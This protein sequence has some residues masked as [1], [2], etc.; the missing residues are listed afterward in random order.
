M[1]AQFPGS[2]LVD[3]Y[4]PLTGPPAL[5]Q[6]HHAL[7]R[8]MDAAYIAAEKAAGCMMMRKAAATWLRAGRPRLR[9]TARPWR[10]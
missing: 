6:A 5:M 1:R 8:A 10:R 3:R 7:D 4:D 2:I 9:P